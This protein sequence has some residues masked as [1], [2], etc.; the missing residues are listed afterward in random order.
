MHSWSCRG[1]A[2]AVPDMLPLNTVC[3]DTVNQDKVQYHLV[4]QDRIYQCNK[5]QYD[6]PVK[7]EVRESEPNLQ[8]CDQS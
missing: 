1:K 6:P 7:E 5:T 3:Q 2:N 4:K 8:S